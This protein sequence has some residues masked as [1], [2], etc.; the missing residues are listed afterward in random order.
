[1]AA[2]GFGHLTG[3]SIL[4]MFWCAARGKRWSSGSAMSTVS[5]W[6]VPGGRCCV[7]SE[8]SS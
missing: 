2:N 8:S 4:L 5:T 3:V 7:S 6:S 1:M